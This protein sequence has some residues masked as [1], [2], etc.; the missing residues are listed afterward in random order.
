VIIV[1]AHAGHALVLLPFFAPPILL[2]LGLVVLI[3]RDR[4]RGRSGPQSE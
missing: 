1:F 4:L 3:A 2:S